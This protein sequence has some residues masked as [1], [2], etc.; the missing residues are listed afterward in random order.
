M[1]VRADSTCGL[2][3]SDTCRH[4]QN[5]RDVIARCIGYTGR[6]G[7]VVR[8]CMATCDVKRLPEHERRCCGPWAARRGPWAWAV[9][10]GPWAIT[11]D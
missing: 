11:H 9:G 7:V 5:E 4:Q 3:L 2:I 8:A 1:F 10:L 6:C